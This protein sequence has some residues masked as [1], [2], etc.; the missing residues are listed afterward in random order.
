MLRS[1]ACQ[2]PVEERFEVTVCGSLQFLLIA[3]YSMC[4]A[5]LNMPYIL[6]FDTRI[7]LLPTLTKKMIAAHHLK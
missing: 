2:K 7:L 4:T 6:D 5:L 3:G 1:A